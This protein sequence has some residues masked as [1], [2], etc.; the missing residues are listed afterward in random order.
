VVEFVVRL[1][2]FSV[3]P[4]H[5]G[6]LWCYQTSCPVGTE[7][8]VHFG[9]KQLV[10]EA[11]LLPPSATEVKNEWNNTFLP[12]HFFIAYSGTI[13]APFYFLNLAV[14]PPMFFVF[15]S[16]PLLH[17]MS[18]LFTPFLYLL[19]MALPIAQHHFFFWLAIPVAHLKH[20]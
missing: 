2:D 15:T 14:I 4:K 12:P 19:L 11:D 8:L 17:F 9:V 3:T 13:L 10:C 20:W 18:T 5:H 7:G 16:Y 6:W 1:I